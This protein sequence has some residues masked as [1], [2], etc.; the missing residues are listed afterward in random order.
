MI[1]NSDLWWAFACGLLIAETVNWCIGRMSRSR[2]C[3]HHEP[4]NKARGLPADSWVYSLLID[5]GQRK[6][7][8]CGRC[9]KRWFF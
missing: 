5:F 8:V 3:F 2:R 4:E 6:M 9:G 1:E 7:F